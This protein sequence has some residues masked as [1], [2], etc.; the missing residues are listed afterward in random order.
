MFRAFDDLDIDECLLLLLLLLIELDI[1]GNYSLLF[2]V[3]RIGLLLVIGR[4]DFIEA[5]DWI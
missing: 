2:F 1:F 3:V 5:D 4:D